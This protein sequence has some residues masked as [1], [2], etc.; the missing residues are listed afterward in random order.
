M[1]E[2]PARLFF[3]RGARIGLRAMV[4]NAA[5]GRVRPVATVKLQPNREFQCLDVATT[6]S[7]MVE[8]IISKNLDLHPPHM[9]PAKSLPIENH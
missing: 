5:L 4:E 2:K 6:F 3:F 8:S 1:Q 9:S 7:Y